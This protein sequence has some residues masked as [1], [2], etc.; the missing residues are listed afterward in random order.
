MAAALLRFGVCFISDSALC[1]RD[2]AAKTAIRNHVNDEVA[3]GV[4]GAHDSGHGFL[5]AQAHAGSR[6]VI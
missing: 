2:C 1:E 4:L 6:Y 3:D 5:L